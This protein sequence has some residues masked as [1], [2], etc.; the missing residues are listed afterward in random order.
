MLTLEQAAARL[1]QRY[2]QAAEGEKVVSI[3]LFG[4]EN[5][6]AISALSNKEIAV[7]A[8]LPESYST[9][10]GKGVKLARYVVLKD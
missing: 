7:T 8:G 1:R 2:S 4:I 9:E 6:E 5:A 10:I 3:H